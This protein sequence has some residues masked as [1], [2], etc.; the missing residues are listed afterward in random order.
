MKIIVSA[1]GRFHTY[2]LA[3]ELQKRGHLL[4]LITIDPRLHIRKYKI[5]RSKVSNFIFPKL[6]AHG[7]IR[8]LKRDRLKV[9]Y[10]MGQLFG[11][12][13]RRRL[14]PCDIFTSWSGFALSA[15][16]RAKELGA[17]TVLVRGSAHIEVQK[18]LLEEEY[19]RFG[20]NRRI[21]DNRMVEKELQEYEETDYIQILSTFTKNS[22]IEKGI[23]E[24]KL[25]RIT[26]GIDLGHF[27]PLPKK[28][29][30]FRVIQT[31]CS[32]QKGT[33][34]LVQAMA[35]LN[36]KNAELI[37]VGGISDELNP[38]LERYKGYYTDYGHVPHFEL[39]KIYSQGSVYVHPSIHEGLAAVQAEA[40]ACGLPL[41]C[42]TNTGGEDLIRD[43]VEGSVLP[44]RDVEALKEKILYLYEHEEE[45]KAMG[46]AARERTRIFTWD[47]YGEKLIKFYHKILK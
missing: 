47:R 5:D 3:E 23:P 20:I 25:I 16:P 1:D 39:Y 36:L 24:E 4:K 12:W 7:L 28:D 31:G 2:H 17:V 40:M 6:L 34:Y 38:V 18:R 15:L 30:I 41:I 19:F 9:R 37:L 32:I 43:G 22:F 35:E 46:R 27:K 42:S 26:P 8:G 14:E 11:E 10:S 21:V 33:H 44:I 29:D 13:V 45:R